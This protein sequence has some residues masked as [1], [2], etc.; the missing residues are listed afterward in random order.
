LC[1]RVSIIQLEGSSAS[2]VGMALAPHT[3]ACSILLY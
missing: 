2:E 1:R 3:H